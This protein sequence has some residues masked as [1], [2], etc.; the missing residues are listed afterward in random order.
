MKNG[1]CNAPQSRTARDQGCGACEPQRP[2]RSLQINPG[3]KFMLE[4]P[5]STVFAVNAS[6]PAREPSVQPTLG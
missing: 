4:R 5:M 2:R 1:T 3:A 6:A